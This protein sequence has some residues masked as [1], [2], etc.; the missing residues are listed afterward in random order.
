VDGGTTPTDNSVW[1]TRK[2]KLQESCEASMTSNFHN[3]SPVRLLTK[4]HVFHIECY[5][6]TH[7]KRLPRSFPKPWGPVHRILAVALS[8]F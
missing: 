3:Q 7:C 6:P 8:Y 5:L 4:W 1:E 2:S